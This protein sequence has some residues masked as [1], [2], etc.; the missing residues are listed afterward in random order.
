[1]K[2]HVGVKRTDEFTSQNGTE[3]LCYLRGQ[4]SG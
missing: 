3:G 1:M 4:R 2:V